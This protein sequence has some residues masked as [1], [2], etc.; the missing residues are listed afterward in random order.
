[1]ISFSIDDGDPLDLKLADIFEN[2]G[3][4]AIF[5][6]PVKK[7]GSSVLTTTEIRELSDRFEIGGHTYNHVDLTRVSPENAYREISEGKKALEDILGDTVESFAFP[8]GHYNTKLV[9]LVKKAGYKSCRSGRIVNFQSFNQNDFLLH[10]NLQLYPHKLTTDL[11]HCFKYADLYSAA[12]RLTYSG[13]T[14]LDLMN[15]MP[16]GPLH[17]WCH[18]EDIEKFKLWEVFDQLEYIRDD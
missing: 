18:S 3:F 14:H 13:M 8:F 6:V 16:P 5:Y 2:K 9:M 17:F 10:P 12:R 4:R 15:V 7:S 1:M 11:R